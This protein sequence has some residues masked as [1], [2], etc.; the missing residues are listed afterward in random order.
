MS[1]AFRLSGAQWLESKAT[2]AQWTTITS[3]NGCNMR[4]Q[5]TLLGVGTG[6]RA[7]HCHRDHGIVRFTLPGA[8]SECR[9]ELVHEANP[10]YSRS[11]SV[12]LRLVILPDRLAPI[13]G[14]TSRPRAV[15]WRQKN[16]SAMLTLIGR[17]TH[18]YEFVRTGTFRPD[19]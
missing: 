3:S 14:G 11:R 8:R 6:S 7:P 4:A 16:K 5:P 2:A 18:L 10:D 13:Q 1:E 17:T 9:K 15:H 12:S 19:R